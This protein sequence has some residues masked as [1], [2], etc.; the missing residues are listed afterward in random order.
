MGEVNIIRSK[1]P[2]CFTKI[3]NFLI[4]CHIYSNIPLCTFLKIFH[5]SKGSSS[6]ITALYNKIFLYFFHDLLYAI[7][8][9]IQLTK[10]K[11]LHKI[12]TNIKKHPSDSIM[13]SVLHTACR[14]PTPVAFRVCCICS[15]CSPKWQMVP[16]KNRRH[17][18]LE[19]NLF[20]WV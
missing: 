19:K 12:H 13:Q 8:C 18:K 7:W 11:T 2:S 3:V 9:I 4:S 6:Y 10:R 1:L 20:K 14:Q 16:S 17:N 15:N 5:T